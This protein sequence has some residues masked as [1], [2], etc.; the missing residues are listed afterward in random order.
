MEEIHLI[1]VRIKG[2]LDARKLIPIPPE[3]TGGYSDKAVELFIRGLRPDGPFL[4]PILDDKFKEHQNLVCSNKECKQIL[5]RNEFKEEGMKCQLCETGKFYTENVLFKTKE[6]V[7][8]NIRRLV[9]KFKDFEIYY[10]IVEEEAH[11]VKQSMDIK[12]SNID[13]YQEQSREKVVE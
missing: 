3:Y 6:E 5:P 12:D 4:Y 1:C 2:L 13:L 11:A 10:H 9:D 7:Y 8:K